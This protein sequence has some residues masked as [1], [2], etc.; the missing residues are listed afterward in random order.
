MGYITDEVE[1]VISIS[2]VCCFIVFF[3]PII[4]NI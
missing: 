4:L 1:S 3:I 2:A